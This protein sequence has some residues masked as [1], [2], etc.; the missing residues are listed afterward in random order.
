[1]TQAAG[2][3]ELCLLVKA[4]TGYIHFLLYGGERRWRA[5]VNARRDGQHRYR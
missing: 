4:A 3:D 1:M 5:A 2:T